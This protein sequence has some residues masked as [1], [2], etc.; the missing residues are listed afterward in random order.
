MLKTLTVFQQEKSFCSGLI[1]QIGKR[2][3]SEHWEIL[4][5]LFVKTVKLQS[6]HTLVFFLDTFKVIFL[7]IFQLLR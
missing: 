5:F 7:A 6:Y 2:T 3:V 4:L 1:Q